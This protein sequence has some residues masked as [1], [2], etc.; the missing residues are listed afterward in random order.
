MPPAAVAAAARLAAMTNPLGNGRRTPAAMTGG[1]GRAGAQGL[2]QLGAGAAGSAAGTARATDFRS[3]LAEQ[4][5]LMDAA[6][7][8]G[9]TGLPLA[10]P[11]VTR[12]PTSKAAPAAAT[13]PGAGSKAQ[14]ALS[15]ARSK[16]G[17]QE[18]NDLCERFV[19]QAYGTSGVYPTAIDAA[20]EVV[21]HKGYASLKTAPAGA[22]LY[23]T[24]DE[25]NDNNGH[26][27]IYLGNGRM[28][29][30]RPT[31]VTVER[32][33]TPYNRERFLGWGTAPASFAARTSTPPAAA[34]PSATQVQPQSPSSAT[35]PGASLV[36][37]AGAPSPKRGTS[38]A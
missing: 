14:K 5:G 13:S 27:G 34:A 36:P 38:A 7:P 35:R 18:W 21:K 26:A 9:P 12:P 32:L 15:W 30:A 6:A 22:L 19:E 24:A 20:R 3:M 31:G 17:S 33:D 28:I 29:S 1:A 8:A 25:T 23:F 37:G 11:S 10:A 4:M 2:P 16:V